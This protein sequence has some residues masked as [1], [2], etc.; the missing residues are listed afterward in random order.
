MKRA[1]AR[2]AAVAVCLAA[3]IGLAPPV[4]GAQVIAAASAVPYCGIYW[5][6]LAKS[7]EPHGAV[8]AVVNVRA[9]RHECFDRLVID[10]GGKSYR[11]SVGYVNAVT[12]DGSG[13]TVPLRGNAFLQIVLIADTNGPQS[14]PQANRS[15]L[16]DVAGWQTFR[17]VAAAGA[18]EGVVSV[19]LGVRDRL[20]FRVFTL[21]GP[22]EGSRLVIDVAHQW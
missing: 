12:A 11:Y 17:Q 8:G 6:S 20:P 7:A 1:F 18:F 14:V 19:G 10:Q 15:E 3:G 4:A 5:G 9:G 2:R 22:G 16:V 21:D 13:A